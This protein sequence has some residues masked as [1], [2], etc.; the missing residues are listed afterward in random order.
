LDTIGAV[1]HQTAR[2]RELSP[3]ENRRDRVPLRQR[4]QLL[5]IFHEEW[6]G[7]DAQRANSSLHDLIERRLEV[8]FSISGEDVQL[9]PS[10][11]AAVLASLVSRTELG[12]V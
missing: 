10:A 11:L 12:L 4:Y 7:P 5:A 2:C 1:A 9:S 6:I 3:V 8:T